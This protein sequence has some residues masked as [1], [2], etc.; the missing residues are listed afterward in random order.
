MASTGVLKRFD[1][2][3]KTPDGV[4]PLCFALFVLTVGTFWPAL[5]GSFLTNDDYSYVQNNPH[6]NSG[7]E[8]ENILWAFTSVGYDNWH[9]L[10][11]LS[12]MTD[13]ELYG[14]NPWG[15]HL[16]SVLIHAFNTVLVFLVFRRMTGAHWPSLFAA[17]IFGLHPLRAES[18]AWICER[19][20][21][22]STMFWLLAMWAYVRY[23]EE[24]RTTNGRTKHFYGLTVLYFALG[25][26]SKSMLV[27]LP[28]ILLLLDY[29]PLKRWQTQSK[30]RLILEKVPFFLLTAAVGAVAYVAQQRGGAMQEMVNLPLTDRFE[31]ALSSYIRYLGKLFWP[32]NLCCYY[33]HPVHLPM[34][35]VLLAGVILAGVSLFAWAIRS[36]LPYVSV[37]WFWFVGTLVPVI[38]LVQLGSA[39]MAD[40]YSYI[41]SIG[42]CLLVVW[43]LCDM[44]SRWRIGTTFLSLFG[45]ATVI[46]CVLLTRHQTGFWKDDM[47]MW[48]R[49][50]AVT[51]NNFV[52]HDSLGNSLIG[53]NPNQA[54]A[55]FQEAVNIN[56]NCAIAQRDL[57][58][59]SFEMNHWDDGIAAFRKYLQLN[60]NDELNRSPLVNILLT[61]GHIG[62]RV[63]KAV[64]A[65][66]LNPNSYQ[67]LNNLAWL[68]ATL[69][70]AEIRNGSEAIRL[71]QRACELTDYKVTACIGTLAAAYAEAGRFEDAVATAQKACDL[72][73]QNNETN[74][75]QKNQELLELYRSHKPYHE[76]LPIAPQ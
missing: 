41:P 56:P 1:A 34:A 67:P 38:G 47:T 75:L 13:V 28:F 29:W 3:S 40:R 18:V 2:F 22:L 23:A 39:A 66:R 42:I 20:D 4:M 49:A 14:M 17:A 9:P 32:E 70:D 16:T 61:K 57:A 7:L 27:T 44:A 62:E 51:Q 26:M 60:P 50:V 45:V 6:V 30:R 36:Q 12:H 11:W 73:I 76:A 63:F 59:F 31:N 53:T 72:A 74:L 24:F 15:H 69:P 52:A 5:H 46:A 55:E 37:G 58:F 25:L 43:A 33:P 8:W 71:A 65:S 48:S 35:L 64:V 10:T 19:K 21:A 54:L 68:L